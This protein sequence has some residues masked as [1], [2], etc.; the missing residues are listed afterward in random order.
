MSE[1]IK[2]EPLLT[3][4]IFGRQF[5][6]MVNAG[7]SLVRCLEALQASATDPEL[8]DVLG[9]IQAR[10]MDGDTLSKAMA[11]HPDWF[12]PVGI[13]MVRA[14]EVGGVLDETL[15]RWADMLDR[16]LEFREKL[17]LY[18]LFARMA[19]AV[20]GAPL[21]EWEGR[22]ENALADAQERI[23]ACIFC[24]N[25]GT[26]LASGVPI[27]H[28]LDVASEVLD[29]EA[30]AVAQQANES[31]REGGSM[32]NVMMNVPGFSPIVT[33]L[34]QVGEECGTLDLM[35]IRAG[36]LLQLEVERE[37][38]SAIASRLDN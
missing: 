14:G 36:E 11:E 13:M 16:D 33:A 26:M 38:Q 37:L 25:F 23:T 10:I 34:F 32:H 31:V 18:R 1:P 19:E 35:M 27:L 17:Q 29:D 2:P 8:A 6:V 21:A 15:E 28:A 3:M 4:S 24:M 7:I 12:K 20:G 9:D 5:S 30:R 22:I